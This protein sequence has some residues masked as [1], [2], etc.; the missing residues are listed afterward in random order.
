MG[1]M[2]A[3][4][5]TFLA[6]EAP[7]TNPDTGP[8]VDGDLIA[9][10][11]RGD[12]F[13]FGIL[14]GRYRDGVV[15]VV[16]RMCGDTQVAEEAAQEAFLRAWQHLAGYQPR[17][18]FRAWVYRIAVNAALDVLRREKHTV[19]IDNMPDEEL[20]RGGA[21]DSPETVVEKK[22][23]ARRVQFAIAALPAPSRAVL[24]LREYGGLSY[25]EIAGALEIPLGTVMSRL[26]S[27]R[28]Q[29][30]QALAGLLEVL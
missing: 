4:G 19:D 26:N 6:D 17:Y 18:S 23:R 29:L 15:S 7:A 10:A 9:A 24:V 21:G 13:A 14:V 16:Y 20:V 12:Q 28:A 3:A 1:T 11:Q 2:H 25:V 8:V 5:T 27:A 22:E 30:R